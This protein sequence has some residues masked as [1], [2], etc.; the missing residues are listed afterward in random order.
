MNEISVLL[1][2][3]CKPYYL[4]ESPMDSIWKLAIVP[5]DPLNWYAVNIYTGE[6]YKIGPVVEVDYTRAVEIIRRKVKE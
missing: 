6:S 5:V 2:T 1:R 4:Y 3:V